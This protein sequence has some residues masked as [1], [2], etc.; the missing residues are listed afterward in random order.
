MLRAELIKPRLKRS[1]EQI[2]PRRLKASYHWLQVAGDLIN[3][4]QKRIDQSRGAI[5]GAVRAYEGDS[6][7]YQVIR[8]LTAV[9]NS[10]CTFNNEPEIDPVT[11]REQL[12][13]RGPFTNDGLREEIL[14]E[15]AVSYN[16]TPSQVEAALFADLAEEQLL[17]NIPETITPANLISRYNLEVARGLLYWAKEVRLTVRDNYKDLFKF[18]KLFKLMHTI[19]P[20]GNDQPSGISNQPE[21]QSSDLSG[22]NITLHGPISPFVSATMRYGL[23]FAKFLPALL[24]CQNW[25]MT[26][27]VRPPGA[28]RWLRY[29]LDD[30]TDLRTHFKASGMFD[31][32]LEADF[33]AEFEVKYARGKRTW[34]ISR[35]DE[36]ILVGDSVLIPDFSFTHKKDGRRA[37][38][39]IVGFWH[40]NYLQRKLEKVRQANRSDLILLVY[41]S[42]K[43]SAE[44]FKAASPGEVLAFKKKP[45]LK[46]VIAA[47]EKTAV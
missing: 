4:Y 9:L 37:L 45:V 28:G 11:L 13:Q 29:E 46:D 47:V 26:A 31:S 8:G 6:L 24:L 15:T 16:I 10:Q 32:K 44:P 43:V 1:G 27:D 23:Q 21:T 7:D 2:D 18:I 20:I 12:Y 5:S 39:E 25:E 34:E 3:I 30:Q 38:L 19:E 35:E 14:R 22:Y 17:T 40:P 42:A 33:A 41:E 36:L